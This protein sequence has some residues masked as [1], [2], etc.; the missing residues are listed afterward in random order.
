MPEPIPYHPARRLTF[1]TLG[2]TSL[3]Y[4]H[5]FSGVIQVALNSGER[6]TVEVS[7]GRTHVIEGHHTGEVL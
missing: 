7:E 1:V 4:A 2:D 3:A 6:F 5:N